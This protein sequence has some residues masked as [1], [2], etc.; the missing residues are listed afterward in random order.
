MN[1]VLAQNRR[2][3]YPFTQPYKYFCLVEVQSVSESDSKKSDK[4][5]DRLFGFIESVEDLII[6]RFHTLI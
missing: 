6:V 5:L 2:L 4:E 1:C 3:K